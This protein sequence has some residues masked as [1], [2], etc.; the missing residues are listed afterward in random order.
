MKVYCARYILNRYMEGDLVDWFK[1]EQEE[2]EDWN[3]TDY[4]YS[5]GK[6]WLYVSLENKVDVNNSLCLVKNEKYFERKLSNDELRE[7]ETQMRKECALALENKRKRLMDNLTKQ[8]EYIR[9]Y[10]KN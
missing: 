4:G 1:F 3:K 9:R 6:G 2:N 7:L 8:I 10:D 5:R